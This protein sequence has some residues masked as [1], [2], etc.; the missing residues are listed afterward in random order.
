MHIISKRCVLW[1]KFNGSNKGIANVSA[2]LLSRALWWISCVE[3]FDLTISRFSPCSFYRKRIPVMSH[4]IRQYACT[5]CH[6]YMTQFKVS[7]VGIIQRN[8]VLCPRECAACGEIIYLSSMSAV[9]YREPSVLR[10]P[11]D[12]LR[13]TRTER[14]II[15]LNDTSWSLWVLRI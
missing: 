4:S 2:L 6:N 3:R 1:L 15:P 8:V 11:S 14:Q 10:S 7:L 12:E 5:S 9:R 13:L